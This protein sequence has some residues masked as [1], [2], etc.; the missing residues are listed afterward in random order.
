MQKIGIKNSMTIMIVLLV[1]AF[2]IR[3][4]AA[5]SV[6]LTLDEKEY[7]DYANTVSFGSEQFA[8]IGDID[9]ARTKPDP[10]YIAE[11][12]FLSIYV[13]KAGAAL[14]GHNKIG[15]RSLFIIFSLVGI[16]FIYK[17]VEEEVDKRTALLALFLL[18]FSQYHIGESRLIDPTNL[19]LFFTS[20]SLYCFFKALRTAHKEWLYLTG[21]LLG[22]GYFAKVLIIFL[23][24]VFAIYLW[25]EKQLRHKLRFKDLS[26]SLAIMSVPILLHL[27]WN[28]NHN[29]T[30][31]RVENVTDIG[32]SMRTLYL[33]FAEIIAWFLERVPFIVYQGEDIYIKTAPGY[34]FL[35]GISTEFPVAH[36]V[37]GILIISGFLYYAKKSRRKNSLILFSF[38]MFS[39]IFIVTSI[40]AGANSLFDDHWWG[41]QTI[42]P[43]IILCSSMLCSLIQKYRFMKIAIIGLILYLMFHS[44]I[45][46][47]LPESEF[48]VPKK[49]YAVICSERFD[50]LL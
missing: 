45:L 10:F 41:S 25:Q 2:A 42:F 18:V 39:F 44:V 34:S 15:G 29:F 40:I 37:V 47:N 27:F 38:I 3:F 31:Y 19:L 33:Y 14:F 13:A 20:V 1:I 48:A 46:I 11:T 12:G 9:T 5:A 28:L 26:I 22:I 32:L 6:P 24:P 43:G 8:P 23:L 17:L 7:M 36:W 49:K 4:Y 35:S 30:K 16:F 50:S 21:A